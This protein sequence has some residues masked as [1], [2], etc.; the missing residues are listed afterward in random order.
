M[1]LEIVMAGMTGFLIYNVYSD[2]RGWEY[3]TSFRKQYEMGLYLILGVGIY[4]MLKQA[5][6][7]G[8]AVL[9]STAEYV[10]YLPMSKSSV[11]MFAPVIDFT[12]AAL[13]SR[14]V[15][16]RPSAER[17]V[18][19]P[20]KKRTVSETKKKFVAASQQWKCGH[21]Q[22]S[23]DHTFEI[24]HKL[25]LEYGGDNEVGNLIALCRNCHGKKTASENMR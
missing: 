9:E 19:S 3:I 5:P 22:Q 10:K 6:H 2:G 15:Q 4:C 23:L 21:C 13:K 17:E 14:G 1:Y 11:E 18:N 24:D 7:R 12:S 25:R 20:R 8:R 16:Q